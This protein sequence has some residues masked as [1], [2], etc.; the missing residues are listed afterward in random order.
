MSVAPGTP[1]TRGVSEA[2]SMA[3]ES[4]LSEQSPEQV[5]NVEEDLSPK[6]PQKMDPYSLKGIDSRRLA[7]AVS[8]RLFS[9]CLG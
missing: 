4:L 8:H 7:E 9:V 5:P 6:S 2:Q 3:T 1:M